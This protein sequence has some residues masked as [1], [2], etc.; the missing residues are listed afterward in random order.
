MELG[1][2]G[3]NIMPLA[4]TPTFSETF[5]TVFNI[6]ESSSYSAN[7]VE[8]FHALQTPAVMPQILLSVYKLLECVEAVYVMHANMYSR[9]NT[10][11]NSKYR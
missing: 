11:H 9:E 4:V 3:D 5:Q 7:H 2:G 6:R 10:A 8:V 1:L